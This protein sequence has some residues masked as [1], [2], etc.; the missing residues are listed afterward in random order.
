MGDRS[1]GPDLQ[2][3]FDSVAPRGE[4]DSLRDD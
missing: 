2:S 1:E 4:S 3:I